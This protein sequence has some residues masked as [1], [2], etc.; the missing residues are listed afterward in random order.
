VEE[1]KHTRL[2]IIA[3]ILLALVTCVAFAAVV[4]QH[5]TTIKVKE[6]FKVKTDLPSE[7][8]VEPG[9]EV[10][11]TISVTNEGSYSYTVTFTYTVTADPGVEYRI[12]PDSGTQK[13][14]GPGET[15]DIPVTISISKSSAS[16]TLTIVW[17]IERT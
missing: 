16:G 5:T 14:L 17:Q 10:K 2:I 9:D 4:W 12:T 13:T 1:N 3:A 11:G 6:P 7:T 8:E 15:W